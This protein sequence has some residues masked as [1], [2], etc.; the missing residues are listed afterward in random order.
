MFLKERWFRAL[1]A[2]IL[3]LMP[4][5]ATDSGDSLSPEESDELL[6]FALHMINNFDR[7]GS[8]ELS[9]ISFVNDVDP[10]AGLAPGQ[11]LGGEWCAK[12]VVSGG[13]HFQIYIRADCGTW[14]LAVKAYRS[15]NLRSPSFA[16]LA[17]ELATARFRA[18]FPKRNPEAYRTGLRNHI[19]D[20]LG[21]ARFNQASPRAVVMPS[22]DARTCG[23]TLH[24]AP[25]N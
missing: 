21:F 17:V 23:N 5:G 2:V 18:L 16:E 12:A 14:R 11:E 7:V 19:L 10:L 6:W 20:K 22:S 3:V 1:G 9:Q 13:G 8:P 15:R 25:S 24:Q 4:A